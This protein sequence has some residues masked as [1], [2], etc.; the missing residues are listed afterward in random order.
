MMRT[1]TAT[2]C[3]SRNGSWRSSPA[4]HVEPLLPRVGHD[5]EQ[6]FLLPPDARDWTDARQARATRVGVSSSGPN[7]D[8]GEGT[9]EDRIQKTVVSPRETCPL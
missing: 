2:S 6:A 9:G 3:A 5:R 8:F 1:R 4:A 7:L